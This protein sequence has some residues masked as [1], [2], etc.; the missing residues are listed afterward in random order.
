LYPGTDFAS[1]FFNVSVH[2][3][4]TAGQCSQFAFPETTGNLAAMPVQVKMGSSEFSEIET[5]AGDETNQADAKYYHTFRNGACYEF[6]LGIQTA[7]DAGDEVPQVDR[8][9]V[10]NRLKQILTTVKI[11]PIEEPA[12]ATSTPA[13][14]TLSQK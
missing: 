11:K 2:P 12:V 3:R 10:F 4:M 6:A 14:P 8:Q 5:S 9:R 7:R 13:N 1:G